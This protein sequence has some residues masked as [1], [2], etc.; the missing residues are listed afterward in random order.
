LKKSARTAKGGSTNL[1]AKS[2]QE[3]SNFADAPAR[4]AMD[5]FDIIGCHD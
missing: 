4:S 1:T 5:D 2:F 3:V